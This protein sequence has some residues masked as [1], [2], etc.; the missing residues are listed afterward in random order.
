MAEE[1]GW[2][3]CSLRET[4]IKLA[5]LDGRCGW[6][7][8]ENIGQHL[9]RDRPLLRSGAGSYREGRICR[10]RE[11]AR[12]F[13]PA[14]TAGEGAV[15]GAGAGGSKPAALNEMADRTSAAADFCNKICQ[16]LPFQ[17]C[18]PARLK[19]PWRTPSPAPQ[20]LDRYRLLIV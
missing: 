17:T 3:F 19:P 8:N 15:S 7:G 18:I 16:L 9:F 6:L 4:L 5:L 13:I 12:Q 14:G 11:R 20:E 2:A 1:F 10:L